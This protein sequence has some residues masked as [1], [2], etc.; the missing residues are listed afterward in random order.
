MLMTTLLMRD[1]SGEQAEGL[2]GITL[3]HRQTLRHLQKITSTLLDGLRA[4]MHSRH[5]A[6]RMGVNKNRSF[7]LPELFEEVNRMSD[8]KA[9]DSGKRYYPGVGLQAK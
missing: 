7:R 9:V 8:G 2:W 4:F 3:V 1:S 6:I 5:G